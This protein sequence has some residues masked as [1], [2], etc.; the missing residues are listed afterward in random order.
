MF[1]LIPWAE[2]GTQVGQIGEGFSTFELKFETPRLVEMFFNLIQSQAHQFFCAKLRCDFQLPLNG[3]QFLPWT[4]Q[5]LEELKSNFRMSP[6]QQ[7]PYVAPK[8]V[9]HSLSISTLDSRTTCSATLLVMPCFLT[10][11]RA[12]APRLKHA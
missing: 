6:K 9:W 7:W 8:I 2:D 5:K 10:N 12:A 1:V 3:W 4:P 11:L